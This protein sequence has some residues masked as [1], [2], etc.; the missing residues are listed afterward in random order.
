MRRYIEI[1][2]TRSE[3]RGF[4]SL[5]AKQRDACPTIKVGPT[6]LNASV[7]CSADPNLEGLGQGTA[8]RLDSCST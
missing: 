3:L 1:V 4:H 8:T 7:G 5:K 6:F 2:V